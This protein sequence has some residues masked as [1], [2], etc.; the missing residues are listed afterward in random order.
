MREIRLADHLKPKVGYVSY[1]AGFV[2]SVLLAADAYI[3]TA[4]K[5]FSVQS[6]IY[7]L[8]GLAVVQLVVQLVFFLHVGQ[9]K[10]SRWNARFLL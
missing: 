2:F 5:V 6:L 3:M 10:S 8:L 9:D 4:Y 7:A 1:G